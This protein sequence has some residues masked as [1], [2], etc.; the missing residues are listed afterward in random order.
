ML[1]PALMP[2]SCWSCCT[3]RWAEPQR[4]CPVHFIGVWDTVESLVLN[5]GRAWHDT[6]VTPET[7]HAWHAVAIDERR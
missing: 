6:R 3:G 1:R 5:A 4:P 2:A 7:R